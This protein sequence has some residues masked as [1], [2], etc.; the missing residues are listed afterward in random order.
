ME[1]RKQMM[2]S[3]VRTKKNNFS[4]VEDPS[5]KLPVELMNRLASGLKQNVGK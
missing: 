1:M 2:K 3:K 5:K 4:V